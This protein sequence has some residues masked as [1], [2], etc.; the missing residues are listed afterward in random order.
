MTSLRLLWTM[1]GKT[2]VDTRLIMIA[3]VDKDTYYFRSG[4]G[5]FA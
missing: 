1:P 2:T 4:R 5:A 3:T